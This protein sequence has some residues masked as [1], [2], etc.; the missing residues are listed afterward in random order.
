MSL[1]QI[2]IMKTRH[3]QRMAGLCMLLA[4]G[5][6]ASA[7]SA[8]VAC[9]P[10]SGYNHCLRY[11][12]SGTDQT[13]VVPTGVT[14]LEVR[15]WGAAGGGANPTYWQ[16]Q[17]G[18]GGGGFS[19]GLLAVTGGQSY[20]LVVGQGGQQ[21]SATTTYGGGGAGG[22]GR[23]TDNVSGSSGGGYSGI[24]LGSSATQA[25]ARIIAGGG[26]GTSSGAERFVIAGGGGGSSGGEDPQATWSGR[27]GTSSAGGAAA[28][29]TTGCTSP[30]TAGLALQGGAGGG[31]ANSEGGGG[32]GGGWWGGGGGRCQPL[33]GTTGSQ[34]GNGFG[35]GG[36][37]YIGGAGVTAATTT[38]GANSS[39]V[40]ITATTCSGTTASGGAGA[41]LY[42]PGIGVGNCFGAGGNGEITIQW[43]TLPTITVT[44]TSVGGGDDF[45]FTGTNGWGSQTITTP[46]A[47]GS[48]TGAKRLLTTPSTATTLTETIPATYQLTSVTCSGLGTGGTYT[49]NLTTGAVAFNA[50]AV[51]ET[52]NIACTFTNV[53]RPILRLQKALSALGRFSTNDQFT[54]TVAGSGGPAAVTTGGSGSTVTGGAAVLSTGTVAGSS[55]T[56][57]EVAAAGANLSNYTTTYTCTNAL[58]GGQAPSGNGTS[59]TITAAA[60]DDLTCTINNARNP[61]VN[62]RVSKTNTSLQGALDQPADTVTSGATVTYDIVVANTTGPD[63][64]NNSILRDP[65]PT[66]LTCTTASCNPALTTGGA[67]CPTATGGALLTAMQSAAGVAIPTL[68]VGGSVTVSVSCTVN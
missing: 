24:F 13:F 52:V 30:P 5:F 46:A 42:T 8:Q 31:I 43:N 65:A 19:T 54:L 12:Y 45:T 59:F 34:V 61:L 50:A 10:T 49:P 23:V 48:V 44:K 33:N 66:N 14:S 64:A 1:Q 60:G 32:G 55:Y 6:L 58:T 4:G 2:A 25:T 41:G 15:A 63:A 56:L 29:T 47:G 26:G 39:P 28:T 38:A 57:N 35:G 7:A 22:A 3:W 17:P 18:A 67:A 21:N 53:K 68:P 62:L 16:I 20:L 9:T 11:T 27:G 36:S 40:P 37:G 51:A